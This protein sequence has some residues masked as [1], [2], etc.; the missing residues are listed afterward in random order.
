MQRQFSLLLLMLVSTLCGD[1]N[2]V[3]PPAPAYWAV[4]AITDHIG[5]TSAALIGLGQAGASAPEFAA[6]Q[7]A[8]LSAYPEAKTQWSAHRTAWEADKANVG[9]SFRKSEPEPAK[10]VL[11]IVGTPFKDKD[12]AEAALAKVQQDIL[13]KSDP[14]G[15][16]R[17]KVMN[18][19][20]LPYFAIGIQAT[21]EWIMET[22]EKQGD[23]W[24]CMAGYLSAVVKTPGDI[25]GKDTWFFKYG[26]L[27]DKFEGC[28]K[29]KVICWN[30]CSIPHRPRYRT[31]RSAAGNAT[32]SNK[33][34]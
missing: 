3:E 19:Q 32:G 24:A 6:A 9:K 27:R 28:R 23:R 11:R 20:L 13:A 5:Q 16:R 12:K 33:S 10:P 4:V 7:A 15:A 30:T 14:G 25:E 31:R 34:V 21:P 8:A 29:A 17:L 22:R 1:E 18:E 2:A 26:A